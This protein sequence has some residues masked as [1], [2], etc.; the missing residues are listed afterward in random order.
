[1]KKV[2]VLLSLCC[3]LMACGG[4]QQ[5]DEIIVEEYLSQAEEYVKQEKYDLAELSFKEAIEL[6]KK[7]YGTES[8][9][10]ADIYLEFS[11]NNNDYKDALDNVASAEKIFQKD[12]DNDWL[13]RTFQA[14]GRIYA[15]FFDYE[16]AKKSYIEALRYCDMSEEDQSE[17]KFEIY[18]NLFDSDIDFEE[19]M[20]YFQDA[21][22]LIENRTDS[23]LIRFYVSKGHTYY[24]AGM[25][26]E[27]VDCYEKAI[28]I[29]KGLKNADDIRNCQFYIAKSY[30][31][32]GHC[33]ITLKDF[34]KSIE[35]IYISLEMLDDTEE[36]I[37]WDYAAA[38]RHLSVAYLEMEK[39]D[40]QKAL[41]YGL[42]SCQVY[43][44][45]NELST[46]ELEKLKLFKSV[47]KSLYEE[48]P[49]A[50]EK[51]F[52]TWYKENINAK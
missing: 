50:K 17:L 52:E 20:H 47:L 4:I 8:K 18:L 42:K 40:Y 44:D 12:N 1:M 31:C 19:L 22:K 6:S 45:E 43:I 24:K 36:A 30:D 26:K 29:W 10:V 33:Y 23:H 14:Y 25:A 37:I 38:Y 21:E 27:A 9:E 35:Y 3:T 15:D 28:K 16:L 41:E 39:P 46:E 13:A 32:C 34:E 7:V 2:L 5:S 48:T 49:Y 51:D 11:V